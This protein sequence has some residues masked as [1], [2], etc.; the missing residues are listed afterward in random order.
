MEKE[1]IVG[2]FTTNSQGEFLL[3]RRS[4]HESVLPGYWDIPGGTLED[5]EDPAAGA[6]RETQEES[7]LSI[8]DPELFFQ[9]SKVDT[10]KNKQFVMLVFH[11]KSPETPVV[12]NPEDHDSYAWIH[13]SKISQY[14]FV[15]YLPKCLAAYAKLQN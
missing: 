3:L 9:A 12:L 15:D 6:M 10:S 14:K 13:P 5:G 7:G 1:L 2:A 4:A 8:S 11:A